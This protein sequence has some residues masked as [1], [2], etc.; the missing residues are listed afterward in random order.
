MIVRVADVMHVALKN[1]NS[2]VQMTS[3][4]GK[5]VPAGVKEAPY[6]MAWISLT[7]WATKH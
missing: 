5:L 2:T 4:T 1:R 3:V 7:R 6:K